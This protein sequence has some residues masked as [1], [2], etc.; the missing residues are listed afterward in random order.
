MVNC[1]IV[2]KSVEDPSQLRQMKACEKLVTKFLRGQNEKTQL[3]ACWVKG[4][5]KVVLISWHDYSAKSGHR[6]IELLFWGTNKNVVAEYLPG[7]WQRDGF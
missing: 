1:F 3:Q 6:M 5:E 7:K 4:L 2:L